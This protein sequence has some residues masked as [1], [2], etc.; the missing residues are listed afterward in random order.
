M[1]PSYLYHSNLIA[2]SKTYSLM[3]KLYENNHC[4]VLL[5][6]FLLND[7]IKN[8]EMLIIVELSPNFTKNIHFDQSIFNK[9]YI[10]F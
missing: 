8:L 2:V 9:F 1:N 7:A 3:I 5:L 6:V 10:Y 4:I